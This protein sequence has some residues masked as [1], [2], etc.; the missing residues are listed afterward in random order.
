MK[1]I[2]KYALLALTL[3]GLGFKAYT[4][5]SP[6]SEP[7]TRV[8]LVG[9]P[10]SDIQSYYGAPVGV[11]EKSELTTYFFAAAEVDTE[12]GTVVAIRDQSG[13]SGTLKIGERK[14]VIDKANQIG[15]R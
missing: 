8:L 9:D 1:Q 10:E 6:E 13:V 7:E 15:E 2:L 12:D 14:V 11:S 4:L 3:V 5:L